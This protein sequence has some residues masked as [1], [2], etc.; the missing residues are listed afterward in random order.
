MIFSS[1]KYSGISNSLD[2]TE[3]D[4]FRGYEVIERKWE[5]QIENDDELYLDDVYVT[6]IDSDE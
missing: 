3:H 1:F 4:Q 6:S 5:F 2:G